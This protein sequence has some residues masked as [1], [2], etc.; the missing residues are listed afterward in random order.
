MA[1]T[2]DKAR[3]VRKMLASSAALA[4][5]ACLAPDGALGLELSEIT[6]TIS[7]QDQTAPA[8]GTLTLL[9]LFDELP[10][11][12][13]GVTGEFHGALGYPLESSC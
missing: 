8:A 4:L 5:I 2:L 1:A 11:G 9:G 10:P 13:V 7:N 6:L 3:C 12:S